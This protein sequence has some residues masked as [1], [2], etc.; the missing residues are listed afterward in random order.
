MWA[1]EAS[2]STIP[3]SL[4]SKVRMATTE[5][6]CLMW[7]FA[8]GRKEDNDCI[9]TPPDRRACAVMVADGKAITDRRN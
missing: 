1:E 5:D 3:R 2:W 4:A 7:T 8:E 6:G 9:P